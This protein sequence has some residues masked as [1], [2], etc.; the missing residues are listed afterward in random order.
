M[1]RLRDI[2]RKRKAYQ[3]LW[4]RAADRLF[5]VEIGKAC[6]TIGAEGNCIRW[7]RIMAYLADRCYRETSKG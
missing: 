5:D 2:Q 4:K 6:C 7:R 1:P 3:T